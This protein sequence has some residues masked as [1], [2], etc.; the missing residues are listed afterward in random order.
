MALEYEK[1]LDTDIYNAARLVG[2]L[3]Q[4]YID[5]NED[6]LFLGIYGYLQS[7]FQNLV[8]NTATVAADYA[9]EAIPT[10]AKFEKNVIAHALALGLKNIY[11]KP[12]ELDIVL[13]FSEEN[14]IN[15][16]DNNNSI[17]LDKDIVFNLGND[18]VYPYI[19]DYDII[20]KRTILP[21]GEYTYVAR[22]DIDEYG[23]NQVS[24]IINPYLPT[25]GR[26]QISG[27]KLIALTTTVKQLTHS[28]IYKDI[29]VDN[30]LETM[31]LTFEF[32]DQLAYFYVE[33]NESNGDGTTTYHYLEPVYDGIYDFST[34][35]EYINYIFLDVK[36]IRLRFNRES[37]QPKNNAE[38]TVHIF[39]TL[40]EECNFE[41]DSEHQFI[42][43]LVS[44]RYSYNALYYLIRTMNNSQYGRNTYTVDRLKQYIPKEA[45]ARGSISTYTDL[46]NYF[47]VIQTED[48]KLYLLRKVHNQIER[49]YYMY[50]LM[51][52]DGNIIPTNTCKI[53]FN[54]SSFVSL[55]QN[56]FVNIIRD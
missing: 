4:K 31:S 23:K 36:T 30:P 52:L 3:K 53:H 22:Y 24:N 34:K 2:K 56:N 9:N 14:I 17:I 37:Y 15:N 19:L 27:D 10:K 35:N 41:L 26:I 13:A 43:Q 20:L 8:Q 51:K 32:S 5:I 29:T 25:I 6:T 21:N 1:V 55:T 54:R 46:N 38:I 44:D 11:A 18:A 50:L 33:V 39:T 40:G 12:A 49:I 48:C 45:L 16:L 28:T 42:G 47:N 7:I